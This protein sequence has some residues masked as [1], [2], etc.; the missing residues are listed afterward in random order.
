MVVVDYLSFLEEVEHKFRVVVHK[1]NRKCVG[2]YP[3]HQGEAG[4]RDERKKMPG[5]EVGGITGQL[6]G[7]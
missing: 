3:P 2:H 4:T 1:Y 7:D 6:S 5:N